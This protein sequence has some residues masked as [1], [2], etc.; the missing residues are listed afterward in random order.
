MSYRGRF[1]PSPTGHLHFGSL[2]AAVGSW[3]C[4]RHA[5]GE[6]LLRMEDIDPPREVPGSAASIL[7][8]LPA[9]GLGADA[10][11][12]FQSQ[13][14][15]AYDAAF[16][17]LRAAD[18]VFP[19]WCSRSELADAG[20]IH[21]DGRCVASPQAAQAPAWRLRVP[22]IA[23]A[24]DDALQGPQRQN[25]RDEVGDFV[26]RRVEGLYSYQL[27]CVVD[28]AYQRITEVV[29][30]LDLLDSTARQIWL[31]RCLGLPTPAYRHL[32]LVLDGEG[33]KLSKSGQAFPID[34]AAPL[35]ALRQALAFLRVPALPAAAD[36]HQLLVQALA[37]FDPAD[38]PH[39][40]GH[41]VA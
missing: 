4:A 2:V 35:P 41:S 17:R 11:A 26:I 36:A 33:R 8:A 22:D 23:I 15:A 18:Q 38:L 6:W 30:G 21:R 12:L 25:L 10:P 27:A 34:P 24:F 19:C 3:L 20:G 37:N 16:E 28:D 9:F 7:A 32:P 39:C 40:S 1:A 29:R 5:G 13:R 14:I 31:Q